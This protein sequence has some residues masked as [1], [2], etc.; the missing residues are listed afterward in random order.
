[1]DQS[2]QNPAVRHIDLRVQVQLF[3]ESFMIVEL[4]IGNDCNIAVVAE[5]GLFCIPHLINDEKLIG[6]D[7]LGTGVASAPIRATVTKSP[8]CFDELLSPCADVVLAS[9]LASVETSTMRCW[10]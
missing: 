10:I 6:Q 9:A 7:G 8:C 4:G 3:A 1:M 5:G 2:D